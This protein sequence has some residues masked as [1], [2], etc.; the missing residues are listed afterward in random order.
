MRLTERRPRGVPYKESRKRSAAGCCHPCHTPLIALNEATESQS[1]GPGAVVGSARSTMTFT[2]QAALVFV[3]SSHP[4]VATELNPRRP[5]L[6][7][8]SSRSEALTSEGPTRLPQATALTNIPF[9]GFLRPFD[10]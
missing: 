1:Q 4:G 9:M 5:P 8:L 2:P 3:A 6:M 10:A 7:P